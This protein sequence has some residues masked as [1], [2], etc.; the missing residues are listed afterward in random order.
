VIRYV[1]GTNLLAYPLTIAVALLVG[2]GADLL[3]NHR[4]DLRLNGIIEI[5][6][7]VGL[8]IWAGAPKASTTE[9]QSSLS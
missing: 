7:A 1:F 6:V 8:L 4:S 3:Q 5:V 9:T 2:N